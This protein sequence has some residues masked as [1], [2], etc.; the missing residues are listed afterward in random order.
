ML[1]KDINNLNSQCGTK[2]TGY[3]VQSHILTACSIGCFVFGLIYGF[4]FL[5]DSPGYRK[6]LL[7]L[8]AYESNFKRFMKVITY[9][10]CAGVPFLFFYGISKLFVRNAYGEYILSCLAATGA[11]IGLSYF[12][13]IVT[14]KCNIMTLLPGSA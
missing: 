12:A 11:G 1:E 4:V 2:L 6:Y 8:W 9:A 5:I 10:V 14:S 3:E 13:P 7:G